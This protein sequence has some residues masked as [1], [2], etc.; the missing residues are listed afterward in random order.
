[1]KRREFLLSS[2]SLVVGLPLASSGILGL[3]GDPMR[4]S[5]LPRSIQ[6]HPEIDSWVQVLAD[7]RIR[8][9]SGK[10]ELGQGIGIVLKQVAAEEL[11]ADLE[12]IEVVLADTA[13]TPNEGFT[14]GSGSVKG[15]AM[16]VR[17]AAATARETLCSMAAKRFRGDPSDFILQNGL[18]S[19]G[20]TG[21]KINI[22]SLL[23]GQEWSVKVKIPEKP[24]PKDRYRW[25]GK[26]ISRPEQKKIVQGEMYFIQDVIFPGMLSARVCRPP[27]PD[28][29]LIHF[30]REACEEELGPQVQIILDGSFLAVVGEYEYQVMRLL[31]KVRKHCQWEG[32]QKPLQHTEFKEKLKEVVTETKQVRYDV[33]SASI[34]QRSF[35]G[36]FYKP[37]TL[38]GSMGP[39]CA[40][41]RFDQGSLTIWS[42]TQGVFPLRAA[43]ASM[44]SMSEDDIRVISVPGAGCFGHN[45][46]D[47]AAADA[48][49][50]AL[51][52]PGKHI[53]VDWSREDENKWEATGSAMRMDV[54][55]GVDQK[56]KITFWRSDVFSD[57]HS[58]RPN[59]DAGTLLG[60][61]YL[62][63]RA[64]M[65]GR[66]YLGGGYRN[67]EPYY[68]IPAQQITA[69]FFKGPV[70]VSSLR[71]LGAY[72]NVFAIESIIE[73]MAISL[74]R[75][76]IDFRI[77]NLSDVRAIAVLK[78]LQHM[79]QGIGLR[80]AEGLGYGFARYKNNDAYCA[81]GAHIEVLASG[82][83]RVKKL[84]GVIDVG[85]VM[86]PDGLAYQVE[87]AMLQAASWTLVEEVRFGAV[88]ESHNWHTY[89]I[90]KMKDIVDVEVAI[91]SDPHHAALGGGEAATPPTPAAITN[92]IFRATGKRIY[93]LPVGGQI[94]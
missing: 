14:S 40:I 32:S 60:A 43:L 18:V 19:N 52:M 26:P 88:D 34:S 15:T 21:D 69:H 93:D 56:G 75:D 77:N 36:S 82:K 29:K 9:F 86:N 23:D 45:S 11:G 13:R 54:Q 3:D 47:D 5:E 67:A 58:T 87:G 59:S 39:A 25:V 49:I 33:I 27:S 28:V 63:D 42:H 46:S 85:E 10:V 72:A 51:R 94:F 74:D 92:A 17:Y 30:D 71:S 73:E 38:H 16:A 31:A 24:I 70:R 1:M 76:P 48:A 79:T 80:R 4:E 78:R 50:I 53:K 6:R 8:I 66:G 44:C 37:Y 90:L 41:A 2:G 55:A 12:Q 84:Y 57:S 61:R 65:K 62:E 64:S 81:V 22:A 91:L 68:D 83:V 35:A 89:P 20:N 7:N